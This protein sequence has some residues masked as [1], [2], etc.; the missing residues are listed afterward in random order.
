MSQIYVPQ[1]PQ[2][3]DAIGR[4]LQGLQVANLAN[5]LGSKGTVPSVDTGNQGLNSLQSS[6]VDRAYGL[7][8]PLGVTKGGGGGAMGMATVPYGGMNQWQR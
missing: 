7:F 8:D 3:T 1:R 4:A 6:A 2:E 5:N